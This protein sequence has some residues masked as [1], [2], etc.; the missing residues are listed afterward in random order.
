VPA[1]YQYACG[2]RIEKR[3]TY[4]YSTFHGTGFL[5]SWRA[6]RAGAIALGFDSIPAPTGNREAVFEVGK[7][8][9]TAALLE[10]LYGE[11]EGGT[12]DALVR[13]WLRVLVR[14][15]EVS[16]R[17]HTFYRVDPPHR[18][19]PEAAFRDLP[20]YLR[21]AE[22]LELGW[23]YAQALPYLNALLKCMDTLTAHA[24]E[25]SVSEAGRLAGLVQREDKHVMALAAA[26]GVSA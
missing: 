24:A 11:L 16:K 15:F 5:R 22:V 4:F 18:P 26:R 13:Y 10:H 3:N 20:L 25:L 2:D 23:R 6:V 1:D 17:V 21:F 12:H 14:R 7:R 8:I 19:I 9:D